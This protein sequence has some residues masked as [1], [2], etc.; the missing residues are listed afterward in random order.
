MN[1][2]HMP[3][4]IGRRSVIAG[5]TGGALLTALNAPAAFAT[6]TPPTTV[7]RFGKA[8]PFGN[9]IVQMYARVQM[10]KT[11]SMGLFIS[12]AVMQGLPAH[13]EGQTIIPMVPGIHDVAIKHATIGYNPHGHE[14]PGV[15]DIPHFDFHFYFISN[16]ERQMID[17]A[18]GAAFV[19]EANA[20]VPNGVMPQDFV[21]TLPPGVPFVAGTVPFMGFHWAD[22]LRSSAFTGMPFEHEFINGSWNGKYVFL[23]PMITDA[24]LSS[25]ASHSESIKQPMTYSYPGSYPTHLNLFHSSEFGGWI[26]A[27]KEFVAQG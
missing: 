15:F 7:T 19:E 1:Q 23:E 10:G 17:P 9:G 11:S 26:I 20:T 21:P 12:D 2:S 13:D 5:A 3:Y 25:H 27:L 14:P 6:G 18:R 22:L 24:W 4:T 8:I 16:A